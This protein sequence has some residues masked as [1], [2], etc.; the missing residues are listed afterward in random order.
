MPLKNISMNYKNGFAEMVRH[1]VQAHGCRDIYMMAGIEDDHFSE[2][3]I[4]AYKHVLT[5]NGIAINEKRIGYGQFWDKPAREV[6][7][8]LL[9]EGNLP[10]A[11]VCANDNMAIAVSDELQKAGIEVIYDDRN[12]SAGIMFADADLLGVPVRVTVGPKNL[13]N[14]QI[15]LSTRDKSVKKLV[16]VE[17]AVTETKNLVR[18]LFEA[19]NSAVRPSK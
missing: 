9:K 13:A 15:E 6:T 19:I 1:V 14:G 16:A 8:A 17:D 3:R 4:E 7:K 5:E 18:E 2:E 11:I 12:V 10:E